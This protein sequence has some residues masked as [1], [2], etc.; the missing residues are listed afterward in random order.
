M[1]FS[2]SEASTGYSHAHGQEPHAS[3]IETADAVG[4]DGRDRDLPSPWLVRWAH[5]IAPAG[6]VIDV[7]CGGGRHARWLADRG[8]AVTAVD[9]DVLAVSSLPGDIEGVGADLEGGAWP[10]AGRHFDAVVVTNYLWRPLLPTLID[11]LASGGVLIY[12]TFA[13]GQQAIG[14]P[15][16]PNFLLRHGELLSVC[17]GL[18]VVAYEDVDNR[19]DSRCVQRIV[20][21]RA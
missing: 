19:T 6:R 16:N 4:D 13:D 20:A 11:V 14:R 3:L 15:R 10:F 2:R 17:R 7:A 9:R 18:H 12:E 8:H 5:L 1:F 21:T